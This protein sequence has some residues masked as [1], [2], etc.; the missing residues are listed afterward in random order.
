MEVSTYRQ[1]LQA[2]SELSPEQLDCDI[3]AED[4]FENEFYPAVLR[5]SGDDSRLDNGHPVIY[6]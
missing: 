4:K 1:L 5:I 6:F 3:T 2:L